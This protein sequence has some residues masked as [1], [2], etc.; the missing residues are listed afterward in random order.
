[1]NNAYYSNLRLYNEKGKRVAV[2][3]RLI[4][5]V[6]TVDGNP[7]LQMFELTC[8]KKD[9]FSKKFAHKTYEVFLKK[10]LE[11]VINQGFHPEVYLED[12]ADITR[13]KWSFLRYCNNRFYHLKEWA[14][15]YYGDLIKNNIFVTSNRISK[16]NRVILLKTLVK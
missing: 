4:S 7:K 9:A 11:G 8:S 16:Y 5:G 13:P 6:E 15:P 1:M 12:V 14:V 2:F 3:G 10:G